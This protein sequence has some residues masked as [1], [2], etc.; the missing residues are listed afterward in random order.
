MYNFYWNS[1]IFL[2]AVLKISYFLN[3]MHKVKSRFVNNLLILQH[4]FAMLNLEK[5]RLS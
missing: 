5:N 2:A 3:I 4:Y 1:L